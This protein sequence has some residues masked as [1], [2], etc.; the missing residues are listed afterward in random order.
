MLNK[1]VL[2]MNDHYF[3][4]IRYYIEMYA[5]VHILQI[6]FKKILR[7]E[8]V[9]KFISNE[10]VW[11]SNITSLDRYNYLGIHVWV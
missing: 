11:V 9:K 7:I 4:L 10:V 8:R 1:I 3:N 5:V 6:Q 2:I